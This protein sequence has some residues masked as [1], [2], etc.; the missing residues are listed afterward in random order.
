M[1]FSYLATK[2]PVGAVSPVII[3]V[4]TSPARKA[5]IAEYVSACEKTASF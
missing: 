1:A 3:T 2:Q 5:S 4:R